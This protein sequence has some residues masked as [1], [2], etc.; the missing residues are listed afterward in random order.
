MNIK[1]TGLLAVLLLALVGFVM[2]YERPQMAAEKKAVSAEKEF[3]EVTRQTVVK[4]T[5]VNRHGRFVGEKRNN[6]WHIVEPVQTPGDWEIFES[7]IS[8]ARA[9]ER[10][11]VVVAPDGYKATDLSSFGLAPPRV[12]LRFEDESGED[13]WLM[14]GDDNPTGRAAYLSWSG[15]D[16]VVLTQR[17]NR[18]SFEVK[19]MDLRDQRVLPFDLDKVV[20]VLI[21]HSGKTFEMNR[22]GFKWQIAHPGEYLGDGS[23]INNILGTVHSKHIL[24]VVAETLVNPAMY[25]FDNPAY[26]F[27]VTNQDGR[28][29]TLTLGNPV[30][31]SRS[32]SMYAYNSERPYVFLIEPF[33]TEFIGIDLADIRYKRV[34]EFDRAGIDR[35]ELAYPDSTVECA[36]KDDHWVVKRPSGYVTNEGFVGS[37][38]DKVHVMSVS[39][40]IGSVADLSTYGL[41]IP[42]LTVSLWHG[43]RLV[44]QVH[45]GGRDESW[46]GIM[47]GSDEVFSFDSGVMSGLRLPLGV[48]SNSSTNSGVE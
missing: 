13:I 17:S 36:I 7:M 40:F 16:K 15:G 29:K 2:L 14:F 30:D 11:R 28:A 21:R 18:N 43:D 33:V 23:E 47:N 4:F 5:I 46:Y 34:F 48:A 41:A 44:R 1:I 35:I 42:A 19:L 39:D 6:E 26:V 22:N 24:E 8:G 10:G 25:G 38:I 32:R 31:E 45:I 9:V 3:L 27:E 37:W 12:E 20:K